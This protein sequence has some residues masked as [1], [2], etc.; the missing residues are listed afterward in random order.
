MNSGALVDGVQNFVGPILLLAIGIVAIK[1]LV[2]RQMTQF[3]QFM[4]I[5][6]LILLL[7]YTPGVLLAIVDTIYGLFNSGGGTSGEINPGNTGTNVPTLP[8]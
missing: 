5:A 1:H 7:F 2:T 3:F 6:I 4:A 8:S